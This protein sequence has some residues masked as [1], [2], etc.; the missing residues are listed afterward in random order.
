MGFLR[1]VKLFSEV[2]NYSIHMAIYMW[3]Y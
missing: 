1:E 3:Y 2:L